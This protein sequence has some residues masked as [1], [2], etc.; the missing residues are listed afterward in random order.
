MIKFREA[1]FDDINGKFKGFHYWG[2]IKE[3]LFVGPISIAHPENSQQF[4]GLKDR[5][6]IDIYEYDIIK[7]KILDKFQTGVIKYGKKWAAFYLSTTNKHGIGIALDSVHMWYYPLED[8]ETECEI[9]GNKYQNQN[10][11][12]K[13]IENRK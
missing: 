4:I 6:N 3:N 8:D 10:L 11:Y 9:I 5:N 13:I 2:F 1:L 7:Y 12:K